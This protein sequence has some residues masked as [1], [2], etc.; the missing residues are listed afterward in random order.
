MLLIIISTGDRLFIFI[1]ID[2]LERSRTP[3]K[4]FLVNF[5]KQFLAE[6]HILRIATKWLKIDQDNEIFGIKL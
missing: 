1:N 4:G 2:D 5:L 3:R 6:A